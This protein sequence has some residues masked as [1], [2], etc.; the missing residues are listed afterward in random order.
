MPQELGRS[1]TCRWNVRNPAAST[2]W[3]SPVAKNRAKMGPVVATK[4]CSSGVE[5]QQNGGHMLLQWLH[6]HVCIYIYDSVYVIHI[7]WGF[8]DWPKYIRPMFVVAGYEPREPRKTG[9]Q[10]ARRVIQPGNWDECLPTTGWW[11]GTFFIFPNS[12]DDDP[13]WLSYF[14]EGLKP[15]CSTIVVMMISDQPCET[16][17]QLKPPPLFG[18][19][20]GVSLNILCTELSDSIYVEVS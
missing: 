8:D 7:E 1:L 16:F 14:S 18:V 9:P 2:R 13:I 6:I 20:I 5:D 15:P 12:W 19:Q 11:F 17:G 10:D 3:G 4:R